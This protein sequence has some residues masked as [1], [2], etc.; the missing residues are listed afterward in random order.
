ML[1]QALAN[2]RLMIQTGLQTDPDV[3]KQQFFGGDHKKELKHHQHLE[4]VKEQ[5]KK[6]KYN[7]S[8]DQDSRLHAQKVQRLLAMVRKGEN[9]AKIDDLV[10]ELDEH[11]ITQLTSSTQKINFVNTGNARELE[12]Q[13]IFEDHRVKSKLSDKKD[14]I[15]SFLRKE[16]IQQLGLDTNYVKKLGMMKTNKGVH[17]KN[18]RLLE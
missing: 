4:E 16:S 11:F 3:R 9:N 8:K 6:L 7:L 1:K 2:L 10:R 12:L 13:R 18:L 17:Y 15:R 5:F 14:R